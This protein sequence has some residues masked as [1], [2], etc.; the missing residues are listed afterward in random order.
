MLYFTG[1]GRREYEERQRQNKLTELRKR[2]GMRGL[3]KAMSS[4][5]VPLVGH[6]CF[7]DILFMLAHFNGPLPSSVTEFKAM[8]HELFPVVY[9]TKLMAGS[10][11][12]VFE[13][14]ALGEC[15]K[16]LR[17]EA[18]ANKPEEAALDVIGFAPGFDAYT[19]DSDRAHEAG[20]DALMTGEVFVR[21][22]HRLRDAAVDAAATPAAALQPFENKFPMFR[23]VWNVNLSGDD[24]LTLG[25]DAAHVTFPKETVATDLLSP[26][27]DDLRSHV[28]IKWLDDTSAFLIPRR[29]YRNAAGENA[30]ALFHLFQQA[31]DATARGLVAQSAES[32]FALAAEESTV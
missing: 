2:I 8:M 11:H 13:H 22:R 24:E 16:T 1:D 25:E 23:A 20:F 12:G 19:P 9:D 30:Q 5:Q 10:L 18:T 3:F 4:A 29:G 17:A 27:A 28:Q 31:E 21:L 15:Y 6:N 14:T 7:Y 32:F 26:L